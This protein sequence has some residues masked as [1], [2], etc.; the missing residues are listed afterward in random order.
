MNNNNSSENSKGSEPA[1]NGLSEHTS[2]PREAVPLGTY[3]R[4]VRLNRLGIVIDAYYE[5]T[6]MNEQEQKVIS[7]TILLPPSGYT[8]SHDDEYVIIHESEYDTVC[9]LMIEP[10]KIKSIL[11]NL[12]NGNTL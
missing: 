11:K 5:Y 12:K 2:Y 7:Y 8:S 4:S 1:L 10:V 9:F 3:V 6:Y